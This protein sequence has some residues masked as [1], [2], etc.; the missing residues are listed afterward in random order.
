LSAEQYEDEQRRLS[1]LPPLVRTS[2]GDG[3]NNN[4]AALPSRGGDSELE[5][6]IAESLLLSAPEHKVTLLHT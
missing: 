4:N 3:K 2:G 1:G 5:R 6:A